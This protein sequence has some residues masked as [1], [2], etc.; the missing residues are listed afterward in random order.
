MCKTAV[1]RHMPVKHRPSHVFIQQSVHKTS[2]RKTENSTETNTLS[3][4]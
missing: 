3:A 1:I 4:P 2:I